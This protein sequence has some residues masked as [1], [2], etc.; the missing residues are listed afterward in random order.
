MLDNFQC[1]AMLLCSFGC[2]RSGI[3]LV[4]VGQFDRASGNGLHLFGECLHLGLIS[5]IGSSNFQRK[6]VAEGIHRAMNLRSFS[7][8]GSFVTGAAPLSG[9]D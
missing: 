9:V 3:S 2:V 7:A 8:L 4:H 1:D 5:L 6:Q